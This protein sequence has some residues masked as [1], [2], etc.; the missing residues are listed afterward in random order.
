M[1]AN[2]DKAWSLQPL[3][4][5]CPTSITPF[6]SSQPL[7]PAIATSRLSINMFSRSSVRSLERA[8]GNRHV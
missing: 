5:G 2:F 3:N 8:Q 6:L 4:P 1:W 7:P